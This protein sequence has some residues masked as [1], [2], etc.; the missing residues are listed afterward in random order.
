MHKKQQRNRDMMS[1]EDKLKLANELTERLLLELHAWGVEQVMKA[2]EQNLDIPNIPNISAEAASQVCAKM[3]GFYPAETRDKC[4][5]V[6]RTAML[7]THGTLGAGMTLIEGMT[8]E[9]LNQTPKNIDELIRRI[10]ESMID[11]S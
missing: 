10:N 2:K 11:G 4:L 1:E 9:K 5:S 6:M 8:E 7:K 3:L